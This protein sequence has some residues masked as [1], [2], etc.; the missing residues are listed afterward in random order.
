M[1]YLNVFGRNLTGEF[2]R[3]ASYRAHMNVGCARE[4][5]IQS[6]PYVTGGQQ[7]DAELLFVTGFPKADWGL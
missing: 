7:N 3:H 6:E 1:P 2:A 4:R 5:D